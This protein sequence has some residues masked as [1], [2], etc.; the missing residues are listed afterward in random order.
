MFFSVLVVISEK[1]LFKETCSSISSALLHLKKNVTETTLKFYKIPY[2]YLLK[3][4]EAHIN[5]LQIGWPSA[6]IK[7][8]MFLFGKGLC[9]VPDSGATEDTEKRHCS[10]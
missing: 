4:G 9:G 2:S 3:L 8:R 5:L 7:E 1:V 6:M 10:V